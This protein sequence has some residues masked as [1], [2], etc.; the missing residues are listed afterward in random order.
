MAILSQGVKKDDTERKRQVLIEMHEW[1][2]EVVETLVRYNQKIKGTC[3]VPSSDW[4][5]HIERKVA[6]ASDDKIDINYVDVFSVIYQK[7]EYLESDKERESCY[8]QLK[9]I[10]VNVSNIAKHLENAS[11]FKFAKLV[12]VKKTFFKV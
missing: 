10:E 11:C 4:V 8:V 2:M 6:K 1:E 3:L 12:C 9:M 7:F 5:D